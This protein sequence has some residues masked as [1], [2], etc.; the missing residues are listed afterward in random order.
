MKLNDGRTVTTSQPNIGEMV[1]LFT[2]C[3]EDIKKALQL[4]LA[5]K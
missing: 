3:K 5:E 1:E 2:K 4:L